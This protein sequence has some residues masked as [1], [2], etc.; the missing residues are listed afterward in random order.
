MERAA[1]LRR[2]SR[3]ARWSIWNTLEVPLRNR[4]HRSKCGISVS[5]VTIRD[6]GG[7]NLDV[8]DRARRNLDTRRGPPMKYRA[9]IFTSE[10]CLVHLWMA[11]IDKWI[12][13]AKEPHA[14]LQSGHDPTPG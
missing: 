11:L 14:L 2:R 9:L 4:F 12:A 10:N 6:R 7:L 3:P 1:D 13:S 5:V 8:T